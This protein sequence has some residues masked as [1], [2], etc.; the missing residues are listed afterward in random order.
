VVINFGKK[1]AEGNPEEIRG[2]PLVIEAYLGQDDDDEEDA[3]MQAVQ[4]NA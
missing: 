4:E 2:N 3:L 1:I